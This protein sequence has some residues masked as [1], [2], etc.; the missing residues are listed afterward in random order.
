MKV[1]AALVAAAVSTVLLPAC[2]GEDDRAASCTESVCSADATVLTECVKGKKREVDCLGERGQ[3]CE[4][5]ACV[6]PWRYGAPQWPTCAAEDRATTE[7]LADK[8]TRYDEIA[9]RLHLHPDLG[10]MMSVTLPASASD[11]AVP[12]VTEDVA[13]YADVATWHTGE[14]D[15]LWNAL[16]L[17]SQAFRY[18]ATGSAEALATVKFVLQGQVDRM[19]IT[20]VPGIYTRQY[21]PPG[22]PGIACPADDASYVPD[23]EKNDNKWVQV[24]DDG[25]VWTVDPTTLA[26]KKSEHCGLDDYAGYCWLENVSKDE[27]SGHLFALGALYK[28]VD[29]EEVRTLVVDHLEQVADHLKENAL[30]LVDWDGRVTEHGKFSPL[31]FDDYPGFNAAMAM[32]FMLMAVEATGREDLRTY[33]DD[34]LLMKS[35]IQDCIGGTFS[36][37]EPFPAFLPD[38]GMYVGEGSC[39]QNFNNIS[40]HMLSMHNLIWFARDRDLRDAAQRSLDVDVVRADRPR[41]ILDQ[42]NAWI[43]FMWAAQKALGPASDGP[44]LDAV[45]DGICMLKQFRPSQTTPT[46]SLPPEAVPFCQ[47]RFGRDAAEHPREIAD[48]CPGTFVWWSDPYG[49][50]TCTENRLSV[51]QPTGYLLPYWMGRYYG[52][53][54]E[55]L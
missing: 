15:G 7:S 19:R 33:L 11:P 20:G 48:R 50:G 5:G 16:Y 3:L 47:D 44:A 52:F 25:C 29:D 40:M 2:G 28:L 1:L 35:G 22:V 4:A 34:C 24:R 53:F 18:A 30:T 27:Y 12:A 42:K 38:A 10:W 39:G 51:T 36:I 55:T 46:V 54:D 49:L 13:T 37:N 26:W 21:I 6:D 23:R 14:N 43:D 9:T 8:A 32:D 17:A 41:R 45:E 31:A